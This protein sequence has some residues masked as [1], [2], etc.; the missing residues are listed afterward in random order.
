[1]DAI[2]TSV[3]VAVCNKGY[4]WNGSAVNLVFLIAINRSDRQKFRELYESLISL[5]SEGADPQKLKDCST[6]EKFTEMIFSLT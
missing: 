2:K 4:E 3:A 5:F 6:F 1:M